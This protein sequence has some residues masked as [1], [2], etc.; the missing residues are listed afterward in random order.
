MN[1]ENKKQKNKM[2]KVSP[3]ISIVILNINGLLYQ[4]EDRGCQS[5]L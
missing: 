3:N 2:A 4:L 1:E 5:R